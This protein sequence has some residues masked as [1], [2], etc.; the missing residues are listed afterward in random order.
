MRDLSQKVLTER[1]S[2]ST[3]THPLASEELRM[4][5]V[6]EEILAEIESHST[7]AYSLGNEEP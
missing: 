6:S 3:P 7:S 5:D 4:F 1:E 2:R